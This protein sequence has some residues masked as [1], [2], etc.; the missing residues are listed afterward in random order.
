MNDANGHPIVVDRKKVYS[1]QDPDK[2]LC[3]SAIPKA[4]GGFGTT[5]TYK[6]FDLSVDFTYQIGGKIEDSDYSSCQHPVP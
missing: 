2:Y 5:F 6:G 1:D 4:Y 3:G